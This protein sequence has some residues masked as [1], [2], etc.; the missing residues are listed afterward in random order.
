MKHQKLIKQLS[1]L[2]K[3]ISYVLGKRPDEF[4]LIPDRDGFVKVKEFLKAVGEEEGWGYVRRSNIDEIIF[5]MP[6]PPVE[7][8]G[9]LIRAKTRENLPKHRVPKNLP[10]LLYTCVRK[11]AY[12]FVKEKGIFSKDFPQVV[13]S[14]CRELAEKIGRRTDQSPVLLTVIVEK[15]LDKGVVFYQ[16]GDSIYF[17]ESIPEDCFTGPRLPKQEGKPK[18]QDTFPEHK[19]QHLPG[20]FFLDLLDLT[21]E[22]EQKK[23]FESRKKRK[24]IAWKK[25]IRKIRKE[26]EK[27]WPD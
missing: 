12:P 17:A 3:F 16:A 6:D 25:D 4:G 13:L 24:D 8:K 5:T 26:K 27:I 9:N 23:R 7:I 20:S 22:K 18:K 21:E 14:S 1:G 19:K 2:S 11:K 15:S 10:K